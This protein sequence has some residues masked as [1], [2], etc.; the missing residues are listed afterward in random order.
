MAVQRVLSGVAQVA[1][2]RSLEVNPVTVGKWMRGYR[3]K[4]AAGIERKTGT[5]GRKAILN[6]KEQRR[7]FR[8]IVGHTPMQ[9]SSCGQTTVVPEMPTRHLNPRS[10]SPPSSSLLTERHVGAAGIDLLNRSPWLPHRLRTE[11]LKAILGRLQPP[12]FSTPSSPPPT[13]PRSRRRELRPATPHHW[14][15]EAPLSAARPRSLP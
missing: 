11:S 15:A 14:P 7:L 9:L 8:L 4:G 10:V 12:T 6:L 5:P 3:E 1:V 2:A 13:L